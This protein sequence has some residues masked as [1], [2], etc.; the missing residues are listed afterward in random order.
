M[1]K[2][3]KK[4]KSRLWIPVLSTLLVFV[5]SYGATLFVIWQ[6]TGNLSNDPK[7]LLGL[8]LL[9][10]LFATLSLLVFKT[11]NDNIWNPVNNKKNEILKLRNK[12]HLKL[13]EKHINLNDKKKSKELLKTYIES[14]Y[15]ISKDAYF[16]FG[17]Y[18]GKFFDVLADHFEEN[19]GKKVVKCSVEKRISNGKKFKSGLIENTV[20][21]VITHP[22]LK[23]DAYTFEEDDSYVECRRCKLVR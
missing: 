12:N 11:V 23:V 6:N 2:L 10:V 14:K 13:I 15:F 17:A 8:F 21:D 5:V 3:V 18:R 22:V 16:Y 9:A 19:I 7:Q 4:S 20:K 1:S